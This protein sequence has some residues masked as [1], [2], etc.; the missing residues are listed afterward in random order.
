[1]L[2][3]PRIP[4]QFGFIVVALGRSE[5]TAYAA[6]HRLVRELTNFPGACP[7][8][9]NQPNAYMPLNWE[10][11]SLEVLESLELDKFAEASDEKECSA[12]SNV[13]SGLLREEERWSPAQLEALRF[14]GAVLSM[15]LRPEHASE[16]YGPMFVFG[17]DR[18][19]LPSD[20][21]RPALMALLPWAAALADHEL[22]ARFL[23]LIWV[24]A[25]SVE[26][27]RGA[28]KA[29]LDSALRL[30]TVKWSECERRVE[31]AVRLA[32][33]LGKG[34]VALRDAALC[35]AEA[36]AFRQ[37]VDDSS[38]LTLHL[39]RLLLEFR[40]GDAQ[41]MAQVVN[42]AAERAEGALEFW[43]A[44]DHFQTAADCFGQ[45]K[46]AAAQTTALMR[47]A[48]ALAKEAEAAVTQQG[49]GATAGAIV[50]A[51][52]IDAMRKV[53]GGKLRADELHL[54]LL[55]LQCDG[56]SDMQ[57]I[58]TGFNGTEIVERALAAV[59]GKCFRDAVWQ[60]C[61]MTRP[62]S[63]EEL[64]KQVEKQAKIAVLGSLFHSDIVNSRGRV[65]AKS[66]PLAMGVTDPTDA[67]L[68]FRMFQQARLG[69]NVAVQ[70]M[71]NPARLEITATHNPAR[72]DVL[73]L[74][75]HSPWVPQGHIESIVRALV[76]GFHGDMLVAGHLIS[77]QFEAVVR[78]VVEAAGGA[79]SNFDSQGLQPE[80]T[81]I[82]LLKADGAKKAFGEAG[83][84][85]L[86]DLL[87]DQL[88]TNL[89]NEV[90]HGLRDDG[91]LFDSDVLYV[92]WS[93]LRYCVL[94]SALVEA[95]DAENEGVTDGSST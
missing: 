64:R 6:D 38:Y 3:Q 34:E 12:Y 48:E 45:A 89:R 19:A 59:R 14:S 10:L 51:Q 32:T 18:S 4:R 91:S 74:I 77:I 22:R 16:P 60:L 76:A 27:A 85:E 43:R 35:E 44:R 79:T 80:K 36:M 83:V 62:P 75:Q 17:N 39:V 71:L 90:A 20:F 82:Q 88:G 42:A 25:R 61:K 47:T 21:P 5:R 29:Y 28:F 86:E 68:R 9:T 37:S 67:G 94:T 72:R 63:R 31:R 33:S 26:A 69:R 49:R 70:A 93:L 55:E 54:R 87:V 78:H 8:Y 53:P 15:M 65:V 84:F 11:I 52:A 56:M 7:C 2:S 50:M 1:M 40:Y 66:P 81:L 30:E 57:P 58:S 92:W 23:D 73:E 41:R 13:V 46:D 95:R 24:Q